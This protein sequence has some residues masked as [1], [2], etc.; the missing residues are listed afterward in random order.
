MATDVVD[1]TDITLGTQGQLEYVRLDILELDYSYQRHQSPKKVRDIANGYTVISAGVLLVNVRTDGT[2]ALMD[3]GHRRAAAQLNNMDRHASLVWYGLT[4]QQEVEVWRK[5]NTNRKQPDRVEV[6]HAALAGGDMKARI[7]RDAIAK[8][9]V[10]V[11]TRT[12]GRTGVKHANELV[13]IAA[14]YNVYD[15]YDAQTITYVLRSLRSYWPDDRLAIS[16]KMIHGFTIFQGAFRGRFDEK[17][18]VKKIHTMSLKTFLRDAAAAKLSYDAGEW[19]AIARHFWRTYNDSLP[20][21]NRLP[22][23]L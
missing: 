12:G 19:K 20:G 13:A 2:W 5:C 3:G 15:Q 6:Y 11:A 23:I 9:D 21:K 14:C 7:I 4:Y 17:R 10:V 1:I 22:D 8:A 18:M 16:D